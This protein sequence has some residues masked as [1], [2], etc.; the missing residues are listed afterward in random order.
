MTADCAQ[1]SRS[2]HKNGLRIKP[3]S[4]EIGSARNRDILREERRNSEMDT[5]KTG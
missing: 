2:P 5:A 3:A 4:A 1:G